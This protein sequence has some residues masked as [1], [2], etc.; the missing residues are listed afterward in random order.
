MLR[1]TTQKI[2]TGLRLKL[3]G[4]LSGPWLAE[5]ERAWSELAKPARNGCVIVD[6]TEVTHIDP[7]GRR[8]LEQMHQRGVKLTGCGIMIR[9]IIQQ[10]ELSAGASKA[11]PH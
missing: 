4:K 1:I 3:D 2:G 11:R 9:D 10:I 5:L 6:I 7:D 8:L